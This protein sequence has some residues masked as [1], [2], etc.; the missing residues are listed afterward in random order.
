MIRCWP[1]E[2]MQV[3][4]HIPKGMDIRVVVMVPNE[5]YGRRL[6]SPR[7]R[8]TSVPVVAGIRKASARGG[9]GPMSEPPFD[10]LEPHY[11]A[12][13]AMHMGDCM[14]C[15]HLQGSPIHSPFR[16]KEFEARRERADAE[17]TSCALDIVERDF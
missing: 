5:L 11:Y 7:P 10:E 2:F 14:V 16:V 15:G 9:A 8:F 3:W 4:P 13:S 1:H 12:P 6:A 17:D